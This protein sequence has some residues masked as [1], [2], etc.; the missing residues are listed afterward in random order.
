MNDIYQDK[1][2]ELEAKIAKAEQERDAWRGKST[3]N[4][5]MAD[6]MVKSLNKQLQKLLSERQP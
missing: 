3:H 4:F 2:A 1:L 6:A 5:T